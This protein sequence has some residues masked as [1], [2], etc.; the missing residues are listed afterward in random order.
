MSMATAL[1]TNAAPTPMVISVN[2]FKLRVTMERQPR[3]KNGQPAHQTTGRVSAN[4]S[5]REVSLSAQGCLAS[6]G[7]K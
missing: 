1:K 4:C 2:M 7:I 3:A 6:A 5:Q